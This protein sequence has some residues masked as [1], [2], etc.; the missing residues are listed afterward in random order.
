MGGVGLFDLYS[1]G[2]RSAFGEELPHEVFRQVP[3]RGSSHPPT[4]CLFSSVVFPD[5]AG[6]ILA[7]VF[8][9]RTEMNI[10]EPTYDRW[11]W[12]P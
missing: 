7:T 1:S 4:T 11:V 10:H 2:D 12:L 3:L 8:L 6:T 5:V 9:E